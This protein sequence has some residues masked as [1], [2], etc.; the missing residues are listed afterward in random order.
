[1]NRLSTFAAVP[2]REL[3]VIGYAFDSAG[4]RPRLFTRLVEA[5]IDCTSAAR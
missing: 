4:G 5:R 3:L 1:M 2:G